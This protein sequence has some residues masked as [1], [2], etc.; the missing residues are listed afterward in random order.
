[1][2]KIFSSDSEIVPSGLPSLGFAL[3]SAGLYLGLVIAIAERINRRWG[4]DPE[5]TRKIVHIGAGNVVILAWLLDIPAGVG[6]AAAA[7]AASIALVS[8]F[9]PILPSINSV[10]R[11]S[12]G[13]FFYALSIGILV[14]VF[15]SLHCPRF[16][17]IGIS[18]MAWGD[19]LAAI[20]GQRWGAHPY[21]IWGMRKSWEGSL[22]MFGVSFMAVGL[23]LGLTSGNWTIG[24]MIAS[25]VAVAA[26]G[27]ESFSAWGLDNLTVPLGSA[28]L[29]YYLSQGLIL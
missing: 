2:L 22:A 10:G 1:M 24:L 25:V 14:G 15:W 13:T 7:V 6:V 19:G 28:F 27:L 3:G 21:Q 12:L 11:R 17:A 18:V 16:A 26:T 29:T 23:L 4:K 8:Y 20:V 5:L 9:L